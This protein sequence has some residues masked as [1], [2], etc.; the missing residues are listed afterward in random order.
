MEKTYKFS[1][2]INN[3]KGSFSPTK[4]V[5]IGDLAPIISTLKNAIDSEDGS[6]CTLYDISNHGYTPRFITN[7]KKQFENFV[8]VHQNIEERTF[9]D[10]RAKELKYAK[11][12]KSS[13]RKGSFL[14]PFVGMKR[15]PIARIIPTHINKAVDT[16][17]SITD[18]YGVISE[19]GSPSISGKPHIFL[20]GMNYKIYISANQDIDLRNYYRTKRISLKVKQKISIKS[21]RIISAQLIGFDVPT[22]GDIMSNIRSLPPEDLSFL[23]HINSVDDIINMLKS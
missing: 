19:I 20:D 10:L 7:S 14:E 23:Q 8:S 18:I 13:L 9:E 2:T 5:D 6:Y 17:S 1:L 16:Y 3:S 22:E 21:K 4:G 11:A 15:K 12:I